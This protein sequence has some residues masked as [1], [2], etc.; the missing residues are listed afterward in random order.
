MKCFNVMLLGLS[1]VGPGLAFADYWVSISS[2]KGYAEAEAE[3]KRLNAKSSEEFQLAGVQTDKGYFYRVTRGPYESRWEA[4]EAQAKM[5]RAGSEPGWI[6][7]ST[8]RR[9]SDTPS[10][11]VVENFS[12]G[13]AHME[14]SEQTYGAKKSF[15]FSEGKQSAGVEI[16]SLQETQTEESSSDVVAQHKRDILIDGALIQRV[17]EAGKE[18]RDS[19][20]SAVVNR[21]RR[22]AADDVGRSVEPLSRRQRL[23]VGVSPK[24]PGEPVNIADANKFLIDVEFANVPIHVAAQMLS[25]IIGKNII[26]GAEVEGNLNLAFYEVPWDVALAT[27]LSVKGL[28]Q[29]E[30]K[31]TGIIRW[32]EPRVLDKWLEAEVKRAEELKR[33]ELVNQTEVSIETEIFRLFY[34]KP[35]AIKDQLEEIFSPASSSD[36]GL[37]GVNAG[38]S[39]G[40]PGVSAGA[41]GAPRSMVEISANSAHRQLIVRATEADLDLIAQLIEQ[42]DQPTRQVMIEAFIVEVTDDFE[43][44]LGSRLSLDRTD[45]SGDKAVRLSGTLNGASDE[46]ES[47]AGL[48]LATSTGAIFDLSAP[49]ASTALGILLDG[50]R[51]KL[52]LS[53]LEQE[54]YS[55]TISSPRL[56]AFDNEM[57]TIFQ[58]IQVPYATVSNEGTQTEFKEAGLKLSVTPS[59]IGDGRLILSVTVNQDTVETNRDNPPI[60]S[61]EIKTRLLVEDGG[62]AVLGGIYLHQESAFDS[63][64]PVLGK[65]PLLGRL[66]KLKQNREDRREL[67]IF[68]VPTII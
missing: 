44:Q 28:A 56:L 57:A 67:L 38:R 37:S 20:E 49:G 53:A 64:A 59:V 14:G 25:E 5:E 39:R 42:I 61:R 1:L 63:R 4:K 68:I 36:S 66:F 32:H 12:V 13:K 2:F 8:S 34:A 54:G 23:S 17:G 46:E 50:E 52:E 16:I 35:E 47:A 15:R 48:S 22:K 27:I 58:G 55:R 62:M 10:D 60:T 21:N 11:E 3:L 51:L 18:R 43:H 40:L 65:V 31:T 33:Q 19:I 41:A 45:G 9:Y 29:Y 24:R 26:L 6:W 7:M 30:D